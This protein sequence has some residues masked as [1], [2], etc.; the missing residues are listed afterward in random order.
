M[1]RAKRTPTGSDP[2]RSLALSLILLSGI[3]GI[4]LSSPAATAAPPT[5]TILSPTDDAVIGNGSAVTVIFTV[6]EFNLTKPGTGGPVNPNEGH[7]DVYV[8]DVLTRKTS[9]LAIDLALPSGTHGIRLQ[10]VADDGTALDPDVTAT[11][12]VTVTRGPTAGTPSITILGPTEGSVRGSDVAVS[13]RVRNFALVPPGGPPDVPNEGH[14]HVFLDGIFYAEHTEYE[15]VHFG[16]D[17]DGVYNVTLQLV[18]NGHRS[19]T[20]DASAT[21]R[22]QSEDLLGRTPDY[23]LELAAVNALLGLG[24]LAVLLVRGWKVKR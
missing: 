10:L 22:F 13:F 3:L 17:E 7:V 12:R 15:P 23:N 24:I 6:S 5:L 14:I 2:V 18:D 19:L 1:T 20:P 21:V 4:P 9:E 16:I 8:D 11:V